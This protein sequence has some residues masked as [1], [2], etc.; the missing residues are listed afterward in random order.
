MFPSSKY[1]YVRPPVII[2]QKI[3]NFPNLSMS[4]SQHTSLYATKKRKMSNSILVAK[5]SKT[6]NSS[7]VVF[8]WKNV[9]LTNYAHHTQFK[10]KINKASFQTRIPWET[11]K[12][13]GYLRLRNEGLRKH[14]MRNIL[15]LVLVDSNKVRWKN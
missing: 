4:K 6:R 11:S 10:H 14:L 3:T 8:F 9:F 7:M 2:T 5:K 13:R 12:S 1:G 15:Q